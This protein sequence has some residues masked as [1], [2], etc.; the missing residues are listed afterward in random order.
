VVNKLEEE[1]R[2]A[3]HRVQL[4]DENIDRAS[5][6]ETRKNPMVSGDDQK[7]INSSPERETIGK[8]KFKLLNYL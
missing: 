8:F 7:K 3:K 6:E 1:L 2:E 4:I 5:G